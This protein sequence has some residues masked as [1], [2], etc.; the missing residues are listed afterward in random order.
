M[1]DVMQELC[2]YEKRRLENIKENI[3]LMKTLG[4]IL[5]QKNKSHKDC[6]GLDVKSQNKSRV[7][8]KRRRRYSNCSN[9]SSDSGDEWIPALETCV[10]KRPN[11]VTRGNK[12]VN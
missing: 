5:L 10:V 6:V 4:K 11:D 12:L 9:S 7:R 3:E 2:D 8:K 1:A